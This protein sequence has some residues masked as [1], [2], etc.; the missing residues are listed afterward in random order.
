MGYLT[1]DEAAIYATNKN[2]FDVTSSELLRAGVYGVLLIAAPLV[3]G[4]CKERGK[5]MKIFLKLNY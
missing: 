5:I 4:E 2:G 1:L 3:L